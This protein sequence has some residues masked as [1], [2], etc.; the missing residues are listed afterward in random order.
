MNYRNYQNLML[1]TASDT[2]RTQFLFTNSAHWFQYVRR[3]YATAINFPCII[4]LSLTTFFP[5]IRS[6]I[7]GLKQLCERFNKN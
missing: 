2:K 5:N 4:T 1:L 6:T 7:T 3:V